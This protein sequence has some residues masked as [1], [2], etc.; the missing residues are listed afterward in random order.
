MADL[1][2][3]TIW[4]LFVA[5]SLWLPRLSGHAGF[6]RFV[7][8]M[9]VNEIPLVF[10][11]V[12]A[13]SLAISRRGDLPTGWLGRAWWLSW[14]LIGAALVWIQIRARTARPALESALSKS[15]G[16]NWRAEIRPELAGQLN[17]RARWWPGI[18]LPFQ[19]HRRDV[20]RIRNLS[21]GPDPR[22]HRLDIYRSRH[23]KRP[24]PVL[25]HLHEGGFV[26][27]GKSREAVT[28]LNLLAAHGW[29][30]ISANY[31]LR[32]AAEFPNP[33]V[34]TKR[35]IAWARDH[36]NNFDA[37]ASQVYLVGCS[38]GGHLAASAALTPN[39]P[40]FQPGFEDAKTEIAGVIS[41]YGYL[42][43]RTNDPASSPVT[44]AH[45]EAPP[46]LLIQGANDSMLPP[47][48]RGGW[49]DSLRSA[50]RSPVV[51]AELPNTQHAFDYLASVRARATADAAEAFLAWVRSREQ[52]AK[53]MEHRIDPRLP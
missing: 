13:V 20:E 25:I 44:L 38:A 52:P 40:R 43:A 28:L 17:T 33:L 42:G 6:I 48:A 18:L 29:L 10:I 3:I 36:A 14:V 7:L 30:C 23:I 45:H 22:F 37:D 15:L 24:N 49:A 9:A 2:T 39:Q 11:V 19:R 1:V 34:D 35:A 5:N 53:T 4:A 32:R 31:R 41:I 27:G 16:Q 47:G 26:Q 50:S 21:Y 46:M 51:Y 8:A 12:I